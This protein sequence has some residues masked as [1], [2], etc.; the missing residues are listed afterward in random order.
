MATVTQ[1]ATLTISS[2]EFGQKDF[3]PSR[4]TCE[5]DNVNPPLTIKNIPAET[6][7]L[8][9]IVDDPD[10][11]GGTFIHWLIWNINPTEMILENT[12][13][14]TEG[15]NSFGTASYQGPCPPTGTHRYFFKV[16]ALD[17]FLDIEEEAKLETLEKAMKDHIIGYGELIGV[18]QKAAEEKSK[19]F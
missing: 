10:A 9:L 12:S 16:Y 18:Y 5:G 14:G 1:T 8:A 13:P 19:Y 17:K 4:Y 2:P 15:N 11:P 6:K 7:S 3:I